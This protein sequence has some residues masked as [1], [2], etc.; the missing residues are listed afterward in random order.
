M[1]KQLCK[2]CAVDLA[3]RGKTVKQIAARCEKITCAE[4]GRRRF[5]VSYEVTGR[6]RRKKKEAPEK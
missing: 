6:A 2:P 5:G 1:I 4:C 3:N